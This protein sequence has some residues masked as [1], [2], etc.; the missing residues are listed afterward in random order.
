MIHQGETVQAAHQLDNHSDG[1]PY[2]T[3]I[4]LTSFKVPLIFLLLNALNFVVLRATGDDFQGVF[5]CL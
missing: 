3:A 4:L 2:I 5:L 1:V